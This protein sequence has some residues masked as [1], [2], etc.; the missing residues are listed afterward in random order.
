VRAVAELACF[1]G[2]D[3]PNLVF[4]TTGERCRGARALLGR[5]PFRQV[6]GQT[7][8]RVPMMQVR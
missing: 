4:M 1:T 8:M 2:D 3:A 7:V 6:V 5:R